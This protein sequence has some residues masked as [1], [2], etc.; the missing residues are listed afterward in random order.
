[1]L[2]YNVLLSTFVSYVI[3]VFVANLKG[4]ISVFWLSIPYLSLSADNIKQS[5]RKYALKLLLTL[6]L[7]IKKILKVAFSIGFESTLLLLEKN[8]HH[9][10]FLLESIQ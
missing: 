5:C 10:I 4:T 2:L 7:M 6:F 3:L 8:A 1:M 9:F